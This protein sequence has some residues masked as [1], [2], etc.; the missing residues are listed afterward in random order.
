MDS[1]L[2]ALQRT[3]YASR[4]PTRR[5]LHN[6]RRAWIEAAVRS[7]SLQGAG[8]A[9]EIGP[10]SGLYLPVLSECFGE[11]TAVDV[12]ESFLANASL[13]S[14]EYS[15]VRCLQDDITRTS[16][17]PDS[18]D[19]VLCTEVIEHID[20]AEAALRNMRRILR[21]NG[22]LIL[23]TPHRY[24]PLELCSKIAYLPGVI[25]LVRKVYHEPILDSGHISLMT[26]RS[27]RSLIARTGFSIVRQESFGCYLPL[28]AEFCGQAGLALE[29]R[30]ESLIAG[31]WLEE[32][33]W[34]QAYILSPGYE[35]D[36]RH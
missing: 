22:V 18:F 14:R 10:G 33:L 19:M 30:L 34:T 8:C 31:S 12:E 36:H 5:W 32:F 24:S 25:D 20:D 15:Q 27:L 4:N 1:E 16:L 35:N 13:C 11:V 3:L 21:K 7:H 2:L 23:S 6:R 28:V 29:Q 17:P 26:G 9:I